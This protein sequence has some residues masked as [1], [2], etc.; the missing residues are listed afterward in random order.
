MIAV[1]FVD[2]PGL[3]TAVSQAALKH[4]LVLLTAVR[5]RSHTP[6]DTERPHTIPVHMSVHTLWRH[7]SGLVI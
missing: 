4:E 1:E 6:R 2:T 3:A 7:A 5:S